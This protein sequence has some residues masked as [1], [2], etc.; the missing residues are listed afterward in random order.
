M[1]ITTETISIAPFLWRLIRYRPWLYLMNILAWISISLS[2]LIPGLLAKAFFDALSDQAPFGLNVWSVVGLVGGAALLYMAAIFCGAMT[3]IRHRFT[4]G[5]LLRHNLLDTLLKRPGADALPGAVGEVINT[6]RDDAE[7][8]ENTI[9]WIV[10]QVSIFVFVV[11][12]IG[13]MLTINSRIAL[14]TLLPLAGIVLVA[15][16]ASRR[17]ERYRVASRRT[18]EKVTGA[19]GEVFGAVQAIQVAGAE[20]HVLDHFRRLNAERQQAMV[21]D[22]VFER[23]LD[24]FY[25]NIGALGTGIILLLTA[26]VL[27]DQSFSVG[28]FAL[29]VYN[30]GMLTEF[31]RGFGNFLAHYQQAGVSMGRM[32]KL[33]QGAPAATLVAHQPLNLGGEAAV[34]APVAPN[35]PLQ[36][37]EVVDLTYRYGKTAPTQSN[38]SGEAPVRGIEKISFQLE[39]GSFT[40][41][42][43]RIGAGKT[44]LLRALLGLLPKQSGAICWNGQ[45]VTDPANFFVPGRSAYTPQAPQL[46]STTLRDNLTLGQPLDD[47]TLQR[48]LHQAVLEE[49]LAGMPEGLATLVG[50]KGVRL[51]GGQ[52]QRT[53]AARMFVQ[54][55]ALIVVDDLSSALDV[56]TEQVL[57][58]RLFAS[59]D[60]SAAEQV[61]AAELVEARDSY[62]SQTFLVVSHRRPAL[63]RADQIIVLKDGRIEDVGTLDELLM[64]CAEMRR[65]WQDENNR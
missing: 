8:V 58:E 1:S 24:S 3:D 11:A 42:T 60:S 64:R 10:D 52:V 20:A 37:L 27:Q 56:K 25:S 55:P 2:E 45:P 19:M 33:L 39:R 23:V 9:S 6:F 4:M 5:A 34:P 29:F 43:G 21:R 12:A 48:A 49:D 40:V 54:Q 15:R 28:D 51:S 38:G 17:I 53:A 14:L 36:R 13:T 47:G 18:T 50:P 46:M 22:H 32:V 62:P 65:L 31:M 26:G 41:I 16:T 44:T 35:E 61:S 63:R 7:S 30:L 57:W 59:G